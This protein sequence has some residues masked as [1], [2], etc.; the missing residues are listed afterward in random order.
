IDLEAKL[1]TVPAERTKTNREHCVP[2]SD[3]AI[4]LLKTLPQRMGV[5]AAPNGFVFVSRQTHKGLSNMA[6]L[7][8]LER[9]KRGDLTT[10][11]FRSTFRTWTAEAT[12]FPREVAEAALAH[13]I[14]DR[15]EAA[16]QRS[17]FSEKRRRLMAMWG[18]FC[19]DGQGSADVI[20]LRR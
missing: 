2:L 4:A 13:V 19:I 10:H 9:M 7:K 11:G 1:W 20:P 16:Y 6:L 17:T 3:Q 18:A 14:A 8:V 12:D 15:T 5:T